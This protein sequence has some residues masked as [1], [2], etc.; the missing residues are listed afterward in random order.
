MSI[1]QLLFDVSDAL[2]TPV[3]VAALLCL[4]AAIVE[5]GGLAAELWRRRGRGVR[6]LERELGAL[7]E[8]VVGGRRGLVLRQVD[9]LAY[10]K[11]MHEV[12]VSIVDLHPLPGADERI[13]KHMA[14]YDYRSLR[15][16]ERTRILVRMGP[17]L[18]LMGT[19]IPLSPALAGL[20]RGDVARL[21]ADLRVAF[22]VTVAGLLIGAIA[23]AIS[24][25]RDRLYA[26]DFSDVEYVAAT[27]ARDPV[28]PPPADPVD[29]APPVAEPA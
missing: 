2:R 9:R 22:S 1:E 20:A 27:L 19:L 7:R 15:R 26:Q 24:L 5:A 13:A 12:L 11:P 29:A 14:E 4:V 16:L 18:G 28:T 23:F 6:R 21:T 25:V 10:S 17:A 8:A 3:L